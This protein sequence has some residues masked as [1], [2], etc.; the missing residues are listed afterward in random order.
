[1]VAVAQRDAPIVMLDITSVEHAGQHFI[2][3]LVAD[4]AAIQVFREERLALKEALH[5]H[6]RLEP[7]TCV[8]LKSLL[9]DRGNGL[10]THQDLAVATLGFKAIA[11][12]GLERP[13]AVL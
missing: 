7:A 11:N 8:T 2:D 9:Q 12:R 5:F 3:A 4:L 13:I 10:V 1:M 6:L